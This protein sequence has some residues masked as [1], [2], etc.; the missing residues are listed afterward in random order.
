MRDT[1]ADD[2]DVAPLSGVAAKTAKPTV[3]PVLRGMAEATEHSNVHGPL[4]VAR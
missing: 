1:N 3:A 2:P 4:R